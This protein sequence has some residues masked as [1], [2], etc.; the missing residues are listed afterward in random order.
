MVYHLEFDI[1]KEKKV[2]FF[3]Y[4]V[5]RNAD[6][7]LIS[8]RKRFKISNDIAFGKKHLQ[9]CIIAIIISIL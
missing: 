1:Y 4:I 9:N 2:N 7:E 8:I 6:I 5:T 3:N